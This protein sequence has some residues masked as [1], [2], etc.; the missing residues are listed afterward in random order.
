M[1]KYKKRFIL[2]FVIVVIM[3]LLFIFFGTKTGNF[4]VQTSMSLVNSMIPQLIQ[5]IPDQSFD[6][7]TILTLNMTYYFNET[8]DINFSATTVQNI[9]IF[10]YNDT[11]LTVF[12]PDA[13]FYGIRYATITATD[14]YDSRDSNQFMIVVNSVPDIPETN[15]SV[16][17]SNTTNFSAYTPA[18]LQNI[19]NV[20]IDKPNKGTIKFIENLNISDDIDLD[21]NINI[22]Y[23]YIFINS[24]AIPSFNKAANLTLYGLTFT[25]PKIL[26]DGSDC[27]ATICTKINY[28]NGILEFNVTQFSA[29]SSAETT[30]GGATGAA[31]GGGGGTS[32]K[33]EKAKV[34]ELKPFKRPGRLFDVTLTIPD[35]YRELLS[36]E[37]II[38][39]VQIINMKSIGLVDVVIEYTIQDINEKV[40]YKEIETKSIEHEIDYVKKIEIPKEIPLGTYL[41]LANVRYNDDLAISGYPFKILEKPISELNYLIM[42]YS[43]IFLLA[44]VIFILVSYYYYKRLERRINIKLNERDLEKLIERRK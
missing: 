2:F 6:E 34:K 14:G 25:N 42:I 11:N 21:A 44:L 1:N 32:R 12:V 18:E 13:N 40:L 4:V 9:T 28:T 29:Y 41:L 3:Y 36:G 39:Q 5:N 33:I 22:S 37:E 8:A 16:G 23:N 26:R 19:S 35:K 43:I 15:F 17:T 24:T 30:G 27:P 10:I 38:S 7:D 20:T 31:G